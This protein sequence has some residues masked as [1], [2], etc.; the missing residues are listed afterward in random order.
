MIKLISTSTIKWESLLYFGLFSFLVVLISRL[1]VIHYYAVDLP[2]W[3]QWDSEI[4]NLYLS[5]LQNGF[6]LKLLFTPQN[7]H[8][9]FFT[10][11]LNLVIFIFNKSYHPITVMKIQAM[12]PALMAA[13]FTAWNIKDENKINYISILL[14]IFVFAIP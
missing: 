14:I 11:L 9:I 2:F 7:E 1:I 6:S 3:D 13:L 12:L 10:N 8:R 5:Y 4:A